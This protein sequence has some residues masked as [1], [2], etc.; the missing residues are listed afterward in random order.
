MVQNR[1]TRKISEI[2][3]ITDHDI[4]AV[5]NFKYLEGCNQ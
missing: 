4:D 2:L 1:T 5:G 3:I